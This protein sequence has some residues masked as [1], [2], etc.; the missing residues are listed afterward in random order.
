MSEK[1]KLS[2]DC[3]AEVQDIDWSLCVLCQQPSFGHLINPRNGRSHEK[4]KGY[5]ILAVNLEEL[6]SLNA[7]PLNIDLSRLDDGSGIEETMT[8]NFA[9]WHKS[10][11][12][13]CS[14][15]QV[16]RVRKRKEKEQST[17]ITMQ[18]TSEI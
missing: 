13:L 18:Y 10:C 12:V 4:P 1:A 7:L 9:K 3:R 6:H 17:A 5:R 11:L 15:S 2:S 16:D 8:T 14:R